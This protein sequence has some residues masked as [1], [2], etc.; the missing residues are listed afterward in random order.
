MRILKLIFFLLLISSC[1]S[2]RGNEFIKAKANHETRLKLL[3]ALPDPFYEKIPDSMKTWLPI[4]RQVYVDDQ[5]FRIIG[6]GMTSEESRLQKEL[7]SLNLQKV[8][9]YL[10]QYGYPD[11]F[12]VG[13][14]G[15]RSIAIV[16]QHAPLKIQEKYY[17][18]LI[19]A[20]KKDSLIFETVALLEDRIN[21]RN[22][23]RQF[24]GSQ[25][26]TFEKRNVL[27]PVVNIDSIEN[28]RKKIGIT[29]PLS[30]YL[31]MLKVEWNITD[32]K[33]LIPALEKEFKVSDTIGLHFVR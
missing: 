28:Y 9:S 31:N 32:Y 19:K 15:R 13:F 3:K 1:R 5:K 20:F 2:K 8:I 12:D 16:I 6:F 14:F 30:V 25:V 24:Y 7:D 33:T 27:Y 17:P 26:I 18:S 23:R 29:M 22:H 21:M 4:L 11:K 10:D